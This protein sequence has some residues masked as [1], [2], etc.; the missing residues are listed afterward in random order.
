MDSIGR[1]VKWARIA[2]KPPPASCIL[3]PQKRCLIGLKS[4][5]CPT[6]SYKIAIEAGR[7]WSESVLKYL[8]YQ[9]NGDAVFVGPGGAADAVDVIVAGFGKV[10]VNY[11]GNVGNIQAALGDVGSQ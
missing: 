5:V 8:R 2:L 9:S 1:P 7:T 10:K 4:Q 3:R 11:V 6:L